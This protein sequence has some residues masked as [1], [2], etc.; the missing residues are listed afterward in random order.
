MLLNIKKNFKALFY[1]SL[2]ELKWNTLTLKAGSLPGYMKVTWLSKISWR[3]AEAGPHHPRP[4]FAAMQNVSRSWQWFCSKMPLTLTSRFM[5]TWLVEV[6]D[7]IVSLLWFT[8]LFIVL[9]N[10]FGV[11]PII[12]H[13]R[14]C[15]GVLKIQ[16]IEEFSLGFEGNGKFRKIYTSASC[17]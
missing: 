16:R 14:F 3:T 7:T 2:T 10:V 12:C 9:W 8:F 6:I 5:E 1:H 17:P 11:Q 13:S 15:S 4:Y